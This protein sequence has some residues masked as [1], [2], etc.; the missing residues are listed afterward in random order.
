MAQSPQYTDFRDPFDLL[1]DLHN[2]GLERIYKNQFARGDRSAI[3]G[4]GGAR[5]GV[6][7]TSSPNYNLG[8]NAPSSQWQA[9]EGSGRVLPPAVQMNY[10]RDYGNSTV[11]DGTRDRLGSLVGSLG[12]IKSRYQNSIYKVRKQ[13]QNR[14]IINAREKERV[15]AEQRE[16]SLQEASAP[17]L[18]R[19][20]ELGNEME[21]VQSQMDN[22]RLLINAGQGLSAYRQQQ[23]QIKGQSEIERRQGIGQ[24]ISENV[25][26]QVTDTLPKSGLTPYKML[27]PNPFNP[28]RI[29]TQLENIMSMGS[30]APAPAQGTGLS[31]MNVDLTKS[32]V[33]PGQTSPVPNINKAQN[34]TALGGTSK[35][36]KANPPP[37]PTGY[38]PSKGTPPGPPSMHRRRRR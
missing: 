32:N 4:G 10:T 21:D 36:G 27:N 17:Q 25:A 5:P 28:E 20:N 16:A 37:P 8:V 11:D 30:P 9:R 15:D 22:T 31:P 26:P 24:R 12:D 18:E 38:N 7:R 14:N 1:A 6:G 33:P 29:G 35:S 19:L 2:L 13:Q 34:T 3:E 23:R